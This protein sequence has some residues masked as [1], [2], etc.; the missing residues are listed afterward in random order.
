MV[1][2]LT[3]CALPTSFWSYLTVRRRNFA[4]RSQSNIEQVAAAI[5]CCLPWHAAQY[6]GVADQK[7]GLV[8]VLG[9][10]LEG[11][12]RK[13]LIFRGGRVNGCSL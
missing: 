4:L 10:S 8:N 9:G 11:G 3:P 7:S 12:G 5:F 13:S 1:L 2:P 6:M